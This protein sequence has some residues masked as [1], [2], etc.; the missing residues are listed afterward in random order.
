MN[1]EFD[2]ERS[3]KKASAIL[4]LPTTEEA[5]GTMA[6]NSSSPTLVAP[7]PI[8]GGNDD[9]VYSLDSSTSAQPESDL[10]RKLF[11]TSARLMAEGEKNVQVGQST[12][13]D[14]RFVCFRAHG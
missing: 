3:E 12:I 2:E 9:D 10:Q 4:L 5:Q 1:F 7:N 6:H 8:G 14:E 11:E 13:L